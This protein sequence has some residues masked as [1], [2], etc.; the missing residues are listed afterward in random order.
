[1]FD[2]MGVKER[3]QEETPA[4]EGFQ[5]EPGRDYRPPRPAQRGYRSL[6]WPMILVTVGILWLLGNLGVI[7][8]ENLSVLAR[9]W[10]LV[11]VAVGLDILVGR[12]SPVLGGLIGLGVIG[13]VIVL[14]VVGP[15]MGLATDAR[16]PIIPFFH[17]SA[18]IQHD[19]FTEPLDGAQDA[20]VD[21][22]LAFIE[23]TVSALSSGS[24]LLVEA[25][26]DYV[27]N[28]YVN[29]GGGASRTV[30]LG[31]RGSFNL[32]ALQTEGMHWNIGLTP[33]IPLDL[34]ISGGAAHAELN[35]EELNLR[36]LTL[37]GGAGRLD[38]YLP[39]MSEAYL[40]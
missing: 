36:S 19:V 29:S 37:D 26:V 25:D 15:S 9:I 10:P 21:L 2:E 13:V 23:T 11:L 22:D 39:A 18:E 34:E 17:G 40:V 7:G 1:M 5:N 24:A 27:G 38:V 30:E 35:L 33:D 6:F 8:Q 28:F 16:F 3:E 32:N 4:Y 20:E 14:I 31:Q 12:N